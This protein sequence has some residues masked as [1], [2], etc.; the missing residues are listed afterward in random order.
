M[1]LGISMHED[2]QRLTQTLLESETITKAFSATG[3]RLLGKCF[4]MPRKLQMSSLLKG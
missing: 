1:V 4:Q 2:D 3:E